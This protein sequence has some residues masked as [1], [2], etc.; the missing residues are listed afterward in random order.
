ML[1]CLL[2]DALLHFKR[3]PFTMQKGVF[4][5][6]KGHVLLSY[7]DFSFTLSPSNVYEYG[8]KRLLNGVLSALQPLWNAWQSL[9]FHPC[10]A[11]TQTFR[12][13]SVSKAI[14]SVFIIPP[15]L[16]TYASVAVSCTFYCFYSFNMDTKV[17]KNILIS[18]KKRWFSV[19][20]MIFSCKIEYIYSNSVRKA[21]MIE[22]CRF[23]FETSYLCMPKRKWWENYSFT[24][25]ALWH[26]KKVFFSAQYGLQS[27]LLRQP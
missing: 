14:Q 18:N 11:C 12:F 22:V 2:K 4:Y 10:I 9:L 13:Q 15:P 17:T 6:A 1:F 24:T 23:S 20:L 21:F 8:V 19:F 27:L 5:I 25:E 26:H 3:C 7:H 16:M